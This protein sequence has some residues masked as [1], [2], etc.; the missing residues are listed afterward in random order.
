MMNST[1]LGVLW[2]GSVCV[3]AP[4]WCRCA[5]ASYKE[6]EIQAPRTTFSSFSDEIGLEGGDGNAVALAHYRECTK[7]LISAYWAKGTARS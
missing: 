1:C 4:L 5:P 7:E 3:L 2:E 6:L